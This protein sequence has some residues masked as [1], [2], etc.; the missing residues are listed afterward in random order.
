MSADRKPGLDRRIKNGVLVAGA[1]MIAGVATLTG[2]GS[3]PVEASSQRIQDLLKTT[4]KKD[5][6]SAKNCSPLGFIV[7]PSSEGP[8]S[9]RI[10][11]EVSLTVNLVKSDGSTVDVT[12]R[13]R[14]GDVN[15]TLQDLDGNDL[16]QISN[17]P[18]AKPDFGFVGDPSTED[19]YKAPIGRAS[20]AEGQLKANLEEIRKHSKPDGSHEW[21]PV[22]DFV[23]I[24]RETSRG[25]KEYKNDCGETVLRRYQIVFPRYLYKGRNYSAGGPIEVADDCITETSFTRRYRVRGVDVLVGQPEQPAISEEIIPEPAEVPIT[26]V[27]SEPKP[28]PAQVPVK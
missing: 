11:G 28:A 24:V 21:N 14:R 26:N 23:S 20:F 10:T 5:L 8:V 17:T 2:F 25:I 7:P 3:S 12:E 19:P 22:G 18:K 1:A 4:P 27:S 9:A 6:L 16:G 13:L 15:Y